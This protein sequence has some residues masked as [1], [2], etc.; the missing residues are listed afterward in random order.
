MSPEEVAASYAE[1]EQETDDDPEF[2]DVEFGDPGYE[3][4]DTGDS[5]DG[6][7]ADSDDDDEA[8][9]CDADDDDDDDP[10][11]PITARLSLWT[12]ARRPADRPP[13]GHGLSA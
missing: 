1:A 2:S 13:R 9:G 7:A 6:D 12:P 3:D 4:C 8:G 5:D 10:G 11:V